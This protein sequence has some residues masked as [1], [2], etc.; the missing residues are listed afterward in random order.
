MKFMFKIVGYEANNN[1][2][3]I[4]LVMEDFKHHMHQYLYIIK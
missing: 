3:L 4:V 1:T 2:V